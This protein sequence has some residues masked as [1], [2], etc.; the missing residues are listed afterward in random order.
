[1]RRNHRPSLYCFATT[2]LPTSRSLFAMTK[3]FKEMS[4]R[5]PASPLVHLCPLRIRMSNGEATAA[6]PNVAGH[7][8]IMRIVSNESDRIALTGSST[9]GITSHCHAN[10]ADQRSIFVNSGWRKDGRSPFRPPRIGEKIPNCLK[11]EA[12]MFAR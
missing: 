4:L 3:A 5:N 2:A 9:L 1:M 12:A 10:H 7:C 8:T 6:C 11:A